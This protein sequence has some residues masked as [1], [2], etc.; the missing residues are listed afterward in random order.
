MAALTHCHRLGVT[1]Q[2][3]RSEDS[4][5]S[6]QGTG[7]AVFLLE[8]LGLPCLVQLLE[9]LHSLAHGP[10]LPLSSEPTMAGQVFLTASFFHYTGPCGHMGS[11]CMPWPVSL[12]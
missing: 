10:F 5:G 4:L 6:K 12:P 9:C 3:G 7:M 1:L 2:L 8:P 11:T